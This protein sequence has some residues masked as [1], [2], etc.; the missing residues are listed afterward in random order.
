MVPGARLAVIVALIAV[1]VAVAGVVVLVTGPPSEDEL[2]R[3]A[4]M[5]GRRELLIGVKADQPGV[6]WRDPKTGVFSGFDI[7]IAYM[8]AS[9]LGFR[10]SEVRF[11]PIQSEDRE[12]MRAHDPLTNT[13]ATVDLVIATYSITPARAAAGARFSE[14]YLR[15][16][17]SVLTRRRH[18]IIQS[19]SDLR[20]ERVC[21]ISTSTS[22]DALRRAGIADPR[23]E[24]DVSGCVAGLFDD[25]HYDAVTTDAAILAGFAHQPQYRGKLV[26][27][28]IGLD[29]E[30]MYGINVGPNEA[31]RTLVDLSLYHSWHDPDD[32]R[33]EDA[34]DRNFRPEQPDSPNQ[35][36]A[37]DQQPQARK[38]AV[39]EWPWQRRATGP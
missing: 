38:P 31:L 6:D 22:A 33:W 10:P 21:T 28:D 29:T 30:E 2:L 26:H 25:R 37:I 24:N 3:D 14:P 1:S 8:I 13:T 23:Q 34:Y 20:S 5:T 32:R 15:T 12:R 17:Q 18:R 36:V 27:Q 39:R 16:E 4:G 19:L 35:D 11:L 7:D 9:D